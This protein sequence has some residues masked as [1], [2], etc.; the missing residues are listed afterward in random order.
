MNGVV[1][2]FPQKYCEQD[3]SKGNYLHIFPIG[4]KEYAVKNARIKAK[5]PLA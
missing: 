3:A 2:Y 5:R 4:N 1:H